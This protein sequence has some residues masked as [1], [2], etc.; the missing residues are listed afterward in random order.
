MG[1]VVNSFLN[2]ITYILPVG[3]SRDCWLVDC[4][5]V[6]KVIEQGWHVRGVLLT[7]IHIDHIYGLNRMVELCPDA[8]VC[9][10][11]EGKE[12]LMNRK[13]NMSKYHPEIGDF[14]FAK[15]EN[16]RVIEGEGRISLLS[17]EG[18]ACAERSRSNPAVESPRFLQD[19]EALFTPGHEPSCVTYRI[20]DML[21]T[22]DAY[23]PGVKV[24]TNFPRSNKQLA[25]ESLERLLEMERSGLNVLP[26]HWIEN[27]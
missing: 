3:D 10:N 27:K 5:D 18:G 21:F 24:V 1:F 12:G 25:A 17:T 19:V 14:V 15:P 4:G 11:A 26:G 8:L 13:W 2:S 20:R 7:H 9:T 6:E 16:V 23:I 22:G